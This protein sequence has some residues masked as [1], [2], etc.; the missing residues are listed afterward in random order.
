MPPLANVRHEKFCQYLHL[1]MS[2]QSA[3]QDAGYVARGVVASNAA[4]RLLENVGIRQ[5]VEELQRGAAAEAQVDEAWVIRGLMENAQR[6][7]QAKPVIRD[8]K[9]TGQY[10]WQG[11]VAN[12]AF[13]LIGKYLG[14]F[15]DKPA[16]VLHS[17]RWDFSQL[18]ADELRVLR[19]LIGRVQQE[20][21]EVLH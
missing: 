3:Y 15:A 4:S 7:M 20:P 2:G 11:T 16:E 1:G 19:T 10:T 9:E 21:V 12:R 18:S 14:M 17:H 5:R 13:E 6:A 8:G